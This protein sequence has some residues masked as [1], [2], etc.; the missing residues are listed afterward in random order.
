LIFQTTVA[1][2]N[3][4]S[5]FYPFAKKPENI[6][7][8]KNPLKKYFEHLLEQVLTQHPGMKEFSH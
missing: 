3:F 2:W 8:H 7:K 5:T 1:C 6:C 4:S